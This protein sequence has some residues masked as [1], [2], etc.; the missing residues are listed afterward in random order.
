[1]SEFELSEIKALRK[2]IGMSQQELAKKSGVS[3][4]LIAKIESERLDPSYSNAIKILNVLTSS[5]KKETIKVHSIMNKK[6]ISVSTEDSLKKAIEKM[7]KYEISQVPVID[8]DH[9]QG[10]ISEIT[11]VN[12]IENNLFELSIRDVMSDSPPIISI[13][14][15]LEAASLLLR[16]FPMVI[17]ANKGKI[18]GV[19]TKADIIR[20]LGKGL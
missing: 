3:Q 5:D 6:I 8:D 20:S 12:N 4:S 13:N 11:I 1:M 15:T 10:L 19:I 16:H 18:E 14:S 9:V 7:K 17:I 2:K